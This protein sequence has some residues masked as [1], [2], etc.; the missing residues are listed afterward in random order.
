[1]QWN[2]S[3]LHLFFSRNFGSTQTAAYLYFY[4]F[5]PHTQSSS[6]GHANSAFV[7][8]P[9]FNLPAN[10]FSYNI[11]V[12]LRAA[13]FKDINLDIVFIRQ[14]L[15]FFFNPVHLGT[16]LPNN[17]PRFRSMDGDNQFIQGAFD[18][19]SCNTAFVN[20][21]IKIGS[22]FVVFN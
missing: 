3:L 14:C 1:M 5:R 22:D 21:R 16:T 9:A 7:V 17:Y 12:N 15:E 19:Y 18:H 4:S 2:S 13:N 8:N 6:N 20:T 11:G 10:V